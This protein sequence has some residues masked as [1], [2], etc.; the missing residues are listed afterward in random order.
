VFRGGTANEDSKRPFSSRANVLLGLLS[1]Q[2]YGS[3]AP[4]AMFQGV[5]AS[6]AEPD[7]IGDGCGS[8]LLESIEGPCRCSGRCSGGQT[9]IGEDFG[10]GCGS[11][12]TTVLFSC[13]DSSLELETSSIRGSFR[14]I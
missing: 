14:A 13:V 7:R 6:G 2:A 1:C 10:N 8:G 9:G 11:F 3:S 4:G 5:L 12:R